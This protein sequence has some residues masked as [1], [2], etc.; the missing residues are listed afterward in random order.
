V[1]TAAAQPSGGR[2]PWSANLRGNITRRPARINNPMRR[3]NYHPVDSGVILM[4]AG[5]RSCSRCF[6]VWWL[7]FSAAVSEYASLFNYLQSVL[8]CHRLMSARQS[9]PCWDATDT[10]SCLRKR[11]FFWHFQLI[12]KIP[13]DLQR[14]QKY[15]GQHPVYGHAQNTN[16][17]IWKKFARI[18][19]V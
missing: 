2:P 16:S 4:E 17:C 3:S 12:K 13:D 11:P 18:F 7:Q 14:L 8:E 6:S 1:F 5:S 9:G 15:P 19:Y 10:N